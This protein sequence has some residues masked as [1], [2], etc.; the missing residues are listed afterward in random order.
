MSEKKR[1]TPYFYSG[2]QLILSKYLMLGQKQCD[3][4]DIFSN[5]MNEDICK[6][7]ES[8]SNDSFGDYELY[9]DLNFSYVN[10]F[11]NAR[12]LHQKK[13]WLYTE[14][15]AQTDTKVVFSSFFCM[16]GKIWVNGKLCEYIDGE[17]YDS[18]YYTVQLNKGKNVIVI[19]LYSPKENDVFCLQVLDYFTEMKEDIRSLSQT[20]A[21]EVLDE[22]YII[23]DRG[24]LRDTAELDVMLCNG[25]AS[26]EKCMLYIQ[27]NNDKIL[28]SREA[29]LNVPLCIDLKNIVQRKA[30]EDF[31]QLR[32]IFENEN[33]QKRTSMSFCFVNLKETIETFIE[34][35]V[36]EISLTE[37]EELQLT[38]WKHLYKVSVEKHDDQGMYAA[39]ENVCHVC[40]GTKESHLTLESYKKPGLQRFFVRSALDGRPIPVRTILPRNYCSEKK[41][42]VIFFMAPNDGENIFSKLC[43]E[44]ITDGCILADITGHNVVG[45]SY[46]GEASMNV[47]VRW[48]LENYSADFDRLYFVGQSDGGYAAWAYAQNHPDVP[49]AIY[50]Q[51]STPFFETLE[52]TANISMYQTYSSFDFTFKDWN[53]QRCDKINVFGNYHQIDFDKMTHITFLPY[54]CNRMILGDMVKK[55]K[56]EYPTS[57]VYKT[58]RNR[59]LS[60]HWVKLHGI[61]FGKKKAMIRADIIDPRNISVKINN[62]DGFTLKLPEEI[63]RDHFF[64]SIN[65]KS[66]DLHNLDNEE[67]SFARDKKGWVTKKEEE[68]CDVRKG[69]GIL[70]VY[71]DKIR[72]LVPSYA[73]EVIMRAAQNFA[74][75]AS[76]VNNCRIEVSYPIYRKDT[77]SEEEYE[78]NL[79]V[80]E[81][82][83]DV[84]Y[85]EMN[86]GERIIECD[87]NGI[88][89]HGQTYNGSYIVMQAISNPKDFNKSI[90][91]I[92]TNDQKI[93]SRNIFIRKLIIPLYISGIHPYLNNVAL[94]YSNQVYYRV[95]EKG[96]E[97]EPIQ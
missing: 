96:A 28:Y 64:V 66:F 33:K 72:I 53:K 77:V 75:P 25:L 11:R 27:D 62:S 23:C 58:M 55:R 46:I 81:P 19:E 21:I 69:S 56:N 61:R 83:Y 41:Y 3:E 87:K 35:Q 95:Y 59:H 2:K 71:F 9:C 94:I 7:V 85:T 50:P 63:K 6:T 26:D 17:Y 34:K 54:L 42:P 12:L 30:T 76:N 43:I 88:S 8:M 84:N 18:R 93:M 37:W 97:M 78:N 60:A 48:V 51:I 15:H 40:Q 49:A 29:F 90:L 92:S 32:V 31:Y 10:I 57:V 39:V 67:L 74:T 91:I 65:G 5:E 20:P 86:V 82:I 16:Y 47:L 22:S 79:I 36:G 73:D 80:F 44:G 52:N 13:F 89:Y 4:Y 70:D 24:K 14:L 68:L 45:G 1:Y 38:G